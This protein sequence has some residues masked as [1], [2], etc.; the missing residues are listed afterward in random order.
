VISLFNLA[1]LTKHLL[2]TR[3][4]DKSGLLNA[5]QD[6]DLPKLLLLCEKDRLINNEGVR[7]YVED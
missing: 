2:V 5:A 3:H 6:P 7:K 4:Q 1:M